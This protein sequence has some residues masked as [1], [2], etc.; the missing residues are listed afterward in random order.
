MEN[1]LNEYKQNH[2]QTLCLTKYKKGVNCFTYQCE[3]NRCATEATNI[4]VPYKQKM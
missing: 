1:S 2:A 4:I 3:L